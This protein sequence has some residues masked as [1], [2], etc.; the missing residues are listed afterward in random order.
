MIP[1]IFCTVDMMHGSR[2]SDLYSL[3]RVRSC[4]Y[5]LLYCRDCFVLVDMEAY[6]WLY[7]RHSNDLL[8]SDGFIVEIHVRVDFPCF[9]AEQLVDLRQVLI[10]CVKFQTEHPTPR[11]RSF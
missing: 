9:V 10:D 7:V 2:G 1:G 5:P 6:E 3:Y 4:L 8:R 11:N